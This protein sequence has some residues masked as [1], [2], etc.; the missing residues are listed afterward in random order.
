MI[1][2]HSSIIPLEEYQGIIGSHYPIRY[3]LLIRYMIMYDSVWRV[4]YEKKIY[5]NILEDIMW[6]MK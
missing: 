5:V 3:I 6:Y 2:K 1:I 4:P